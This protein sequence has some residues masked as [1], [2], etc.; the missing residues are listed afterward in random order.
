M[1]IQVSEIPPWVRRVLPGSSVCG[2]WNI[3]VHLKILPFPIP[4]KTGKNEGA[5]I[6]CHV[7]VL[8]VWSLSAWSAAV[9]LGSAQAAGVAASHHCEVG[10]YEDTE[11]KPR[12]GFKEVS[13]WLSSL[14]S[15]KSLWLIAHLCIR[16]LGDCWPVF[17]FSPG[18]RCVCTKLI[19]IRFAIPGQAAWSARS[20][21]E[22]VD[23]LPYCQQRYLNWGTIAV[24]SCAFRGLSE[25]EWGLEKAAACQLGCTELRRKSP[26][27]W[28]PAWAA[29]CLLAFINTKINLAFLK[30]TP[31]FHYCKFKCGHTVNADQPRG[32]TLCIDYD[33]NPPPPL[34]KK[35]P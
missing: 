16:K 28:L 29:R 6:Q 22:A 24:K 17:C 35:K 3:P 23:M 19:G 15:R 21:G 1:F 12:S 32:G 20:G 5:E 2:V 10:E 4:I 11:N 34:K 14:A 13:Y 8:K 25:A 18:F 27:C 9:A 26:C 30:N 31:F 7:N 33:F